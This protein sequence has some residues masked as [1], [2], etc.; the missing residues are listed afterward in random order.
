MNRKWCCPTASKKVQAVYI[1]NRTRRVV[2]SHGPQSGT[3]RTWI[4]HIIL[5][6]E[7][8]K[9]VVKRDSVGC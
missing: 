9:V 5:L 3:P 4:L 6:I 1:Q 8:E 2:T 7:M